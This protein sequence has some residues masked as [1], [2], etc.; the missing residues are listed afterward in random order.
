MCF[1][2]PKPIYKKIDINNLVQLSMIN[3]FVTSK[4]Y[5]NIKF[6]TFYTKFLF[7]KILM[8]FIFLLETEENLENHS[9]C[10]ECGEYIPSLLMTHHLFGFHEE[11]A[12]TTGLD[13]PLLRDKPMCY[14]PLCND[15]IHNYILRQHLRTFH[16]V[17]IHNTVKVFKPTTRPSHISKEKYWND[18]FEQFFPG[19][20]QD[21]KTYVKCPQ[22]FKELASDKFIDHYRINHSSKCV[23][24]N[25]TFR[26]HHAKNKHMAIVHNN[27]LA[28]DR[29]NEKRHECNICGQKFRQPSGV[30]SHIRTVHEQLRSFLCDVCGEAF[31]RKSALKGHR[32][33][34][35]NIK[36]YQCKLCLHRYADRSSLKKHLKNAHQTVMEGR[37]NDPFIDKESLP[38]CKLPETEANELPNTNTNEQTVVMKVKKNNKVKEKNEEVSPEFILN[39]F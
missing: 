8:S 20:E 16:N 33:R 15:V 31:L 3:A 2:Y 11:F 24:C 4:V 9:K 32:K 37:W 36:L 26:S 39:I 6:Y 25:I 27:S 23:I 13:D 30:K 7:N 19:I 1:I 21:G 22:C 38:W 17:E 29:T 28:Y 18:L 5:I 14:C 35:F 34:H 12:K 10:S